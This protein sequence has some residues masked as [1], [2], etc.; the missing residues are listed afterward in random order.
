MK[1]TIAAIA[2]AAAISLTA[3]L[4]AIAATPKSGAKCTS[5]GQSQTVY[6]NDSVNKGKTF[7]CVTKKKAKVWSS[8]TVAVRIQSKLSVSQVWKGS[9]VVLS[10][11]DSS[12]NDCSASTNQVAGA[13]CKGFYIG[14][15]SNFNDKDRTVDYSKIETTTISNLQLGDKGEFLLMYQATPDATPIAVKG[16]PF[17][18]SY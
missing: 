4:P 10:L 1:K 8:P 15:K 18:Y 6:T 16:F 2:L 12:G 3:N 13:D 7:T 9:T 14:W 5:V 11:L 17:N